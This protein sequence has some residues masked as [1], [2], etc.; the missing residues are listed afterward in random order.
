PVRVV[1]MEAPAR[2]VGLALGV[3][4]DVGLKAE[5]TYTK[6]V[7]WGLPLEMR[8]GV[9]LD[10]KRQR[11]FL[12]FHLPPNPKG[13]RDQF[14]LLV[15]RHDLEGQELRRVGVGLQ[16]TQTRQAAGDS[17]VEFETRTGVLVAYDKVDIDG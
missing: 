2:R 6:H 11:A 17:R 12:D 4:S 15:E 13:Y 1:V 9:A 3:A 5:A 16:R 8:T 10:R 14:G 7:V